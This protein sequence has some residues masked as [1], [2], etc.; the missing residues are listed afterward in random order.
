MSLS[1]LNKLK[2]TNNFENNRELVEKMKKGLRIKLVNMLSSG[3]VTYSCAISRSNYSLD[4]YKQELVLGFDEFNYLVNNKKNILRNFALMP[5]QCEI[6]DYIS[7]KDEKELLNEVLKTFG[8]ASVYDI[9]EDNNGGD[10]LYEDILDYIIL[11]EDKE[12]TFKDFVGI[13]EE[14]PLAL[15]EKLVKR[16]IDL[17]KSN[18]L[19]DMQKINYFIESTDNPEL[20][21]DDVRNTED[22]KVRRI[23]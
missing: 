17:C 14:I 10:F 21:I 23:R 8:L 3:T 6:D 5:V 22:A 13:V 15:Y 7:D 9:K 2:K 20:F 16:A 1:K 19:N 12:L 11:D 18:E 4:E